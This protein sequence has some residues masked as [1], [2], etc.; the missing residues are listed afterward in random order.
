[1]AGQT[2]PLFSSIVK[3]KKGGQKIVYRAVNAQGETVALK[4]I[5]NAADPRVLQEID[6]VKG[7]SLPNV[8]RIIESGIVTDETIGEEALYIVEQYVD[9]ISV[10]DWLNAGN[11]ADLAMAYRILDTLLT[12]EIELEKSGILHRD[13]NPNNIILGKDGLVYLPIRFWICGQVNMKSR[14]IISG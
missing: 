11:K 8:P 5:G 3:I 4:I 10:R 6:I 13:I 12:V 9:G 7:L 1:M 2:E 14:I